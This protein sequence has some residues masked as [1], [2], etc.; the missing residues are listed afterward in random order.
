M[1]ARSAGRQNL[2]FANF[3]FNFGTAPESP[4]SPNS[5]VSIVDA[6]F[7]GFN[8]AA[9]LGGNAGGAV[10][11]PL[12]LVVLSG[13]SDTNPLAFGNAA[14]N[15]LGNR[16]DVEAFGGFLNAAIAVGNLFAFPNGSD[17]IVRVGDFGTDTPGGNLSLA[18]NVQPPSLPR[19]PILLARRTAATP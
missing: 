3:A 4:S 1:Q 10:G 12:D 13:G 19:Q 5:G 15:F 17:S 6:S 11:I 18:F 2:D 9:N 8:L 14:I 7:G 16:N